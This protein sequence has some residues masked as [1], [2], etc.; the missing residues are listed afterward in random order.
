[1]ATS[2]L[3]PRYLT[4][5][6]R[7]RGSFLGVL[8]LTLTFLVTTFVTLLPTQ[9]VSAQEEGGTD[10][11]KWVA[12]NAS[13]VTKE[14]YTM[15]TTDSEEFELNSKS[16]ITTGQE[17]V[18]MGLNW[19]LEASGSE[20]VKTNEA[21][22]GRPVDLDKAAA[23]DNEG[24]ATPGTTPA[25][26]TTPT[27]ADAFNGGTKKYNPFDRFGV[28]GLYWTSYKGEWKYVVVDACGKGDPVDPKTGLYYEK[29]L[30]PRATFHQI[31]NSKDPRSE[32]MK[33]GLIGNTII[34]YANVLANLIFWL[35]K[36]VVTLA[37]ALIN[38]SFVDLVALLKIDVLLAGKDGNTGMFSV[39]FD[40]F[41]LPFTVLAF[42]ATA[43]YI[44][45]WGV[46]KAQARKSL[47][48]LGRSLFM[49]FL[50]FW[51][52]ANPALFVSLP[53]N[54]AVT[55]Q[56]YLVSSLSDS[57]AGGS[58]LCSTTLGSGPNKRVEL[59]PGEVKEGQESSFLAQASANM[60]SSI[61]CT[62]WQQLLLRPWAQGQY[63]TSWEKTWAKGKVP[64]WA[65]TNNSSNSAYNHEALTN[66]DENARMVGDA[67]VPL[68]AQEVVHNWA[69]FQISTQT[70]VH[71]AYGKKS[72]KPK[73]TNGIANDWWR[74]VDVL[75]NYEEQVV[76]P[77]TY[78]GT[79]KGPFS[80]EKLKEQNPAPTVPNTPT[81]PPA[82]S[83]ARV[84][85]LK[86]MVPVGNYA[87]H[88][89]IDYRAAEGTPLFASDA[90]VV[91]RAGGA[92]GQTAYG[93]AVIIKNAVGER[94]VYGHMTAGSLTVKE[95]D[96]VT[97]GQQVGLSGNT[98]GVT[99][100]NSGPHLHFEVVPPGGKTG[101]DSNRTYTQ[102]WLNGATSTGQTPGGVTSSTQQNTEYLE[103]K[104]NAPLSQWDTWTGGSSGG[105]IAVAASALFIALIGVA[106]PMV[107]AFLC[108]IYA[109]SVAILMAFSPVMLLFGCWAGRGWEIFKGWA[110]LVVNITL[111]RIVCGVLLVFVILLNDA[112]LRIVEQVSWW[113]GV[114]LLALLSYITVTSRHKIFDTVA[115]VRFASV[116]FTSSYETISKNVRGT[117]KGVT[118][119]AAVAP[120]GGFT[121][122]RQGGSF[123]GGAQAALREEVRHLS[124]KSKGLRAVVQ[125]YEQA[126][127]SLRGLESDSIREAMVCCRCEGPTTISSTVYRQ[128]DG[129][130]VCMDCANRDGDAN[131]LTVLNI[132]WDEARRGQ[133]EDAAVRRGG[134]D[135]VKVQ[136][137]AT[138]PLRNQETLAPLKDENIAKEERKK[139]LVKTSSDSIKAD[140]NAHQEAM[141]SKE[142]AVAR[143]NRK[144]P[145]P[146]MVVAEELRPFVDADLMQRS[147]DNGDY[148]YVSTAYAYA[149]ARWAGRNLD[150]AFVE[151]VEDVV[152][153]IQAQTQASFLKDELLDEAEKPEAV[154]EDSIVA[155]GAVT[156]VRTP[157]EPVA[158][159]SS[160]QGQEA[161]RAKAQGK[162]QGEVTP[163]ERP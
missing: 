13:S 22:L 6:L 33:R 12:C 45:Y 17:D 64:S 14:L 84:N 7:K 81:T 118:R 146:T 86:D 26:P 34:A 157:T 124:Y 136:A 28:A 110:E 163:E 4:Q 162:P 72:E 41:F 2:P 78:V 85:P 76:D 57:L 129:G 90:G 161:A 52:A 79:N 94:I 154:V 148:E 48:A 70:N 35:A 98:H 36:G 44:L 11:V 126:D 103:S 139:H 105:R 145:N 59:A 20:F 131:S 74:I 132:N 62:L 114:V 152:K 8:L 130:Y 153:E 150:A 100:P 138:A 104:G 51:A 93:V 155:T 19:L 143:G 117:A 60:K 115:S 58:G 43:F 3:A 113:Q 65:P 135:R 75:T 140:I 111:R 61:G 30:V 101:V 160:P 18:T 141:T 5:P 88:S 128:A 40:S 151:A 21:V 27:K 149:W 96:T 102:A 119:T 54:V 127:V 42:A 67:D 106:G 116:N 83:G 1:M 15:N 134:A 120:V 133:R 156:V 31:D 39:L 10:V 37:I 46:I 73:V 92:S 23:E 159:K 91:E 50:A 112:A 122:L 142:A 25:T 137:S 38:V 47:I 71:A 82:P 66:G 125:G 121:S 109:L 16:S 53:N 144:A 97:A 95:G 32:P 89:G 63:G 99:R 80:E 29:R 9:T 147:W 108:A 123:R 68:G 55:A 158:K 87:G 69:L 77:T 107:F 49:F 56:A 24:T